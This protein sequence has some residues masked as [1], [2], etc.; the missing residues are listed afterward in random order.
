MNIETGSTFEGPIIITSRGTGY[1][2]IDKNL[3]IEVPVEAVNKA[4]DGDTVKVQVT[5]KDGGRNGEP[6]GEIVQIINRGKQYFVGTSRLENG[7]LFIVPDNHRMYINFKVPTYEGK[8][9]DN[10]KIYIK[11]QDWKDGNEFPEATVEKIIGKKGVHEVEMQSIILEQGFESGFSEKVEAEAKDFVSKWDEI[12]KEEIV[13]RKDMR[14]T[15]TFTIDP[16]NAKDFDDAL[17][18]KKLENGNYEIGIHIADVSYFVRPGS[19]LDKEAFDRSF[20]VYLV[21]RTIPMLPEALSN[22]L[23]SLKPEVERLA[24]S[25]IFEITPEAE[26]VS[27]WYGRTIIKSDKRFTYEEA[28]QI[29]DNNSGEF[30]DELN[31][32][33][34]ISKKLG[35]EKMQ[36]GAIRFERDEFEFELDKDGVPIKIHKKEH[37]DTHSLIEEFMLLSNKSVAK[38]I[39]DEDKKKNDGKI[40]QLM[41]RV[42]NPPEIDKIKELH[43]FLKI[44]G[45]ELRVD[46]DGLVSPSAINALLDEVKGKPEEDLISSATIKTMSKAIYS[47]ENLGHFG[48][49]FKYYTHFTSPIRRYPDLIVHRILD[50]LLKNQKIS[51]DEMAYF[52][53]SA[54]QSSNQEVA[55]QDAERQ[56]IRYKQ[57]EFM[58]N[59]IGEEFDG[60]ISGVAKFG[61]FVTLND[62][63]ANGMV[64]ISNLGEDFYKF[65]EKNYRIVGERNGEKYTL[66][67]QVRVKIAEANLDEKQLQ[68]KIVENK[69]TKK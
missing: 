15:T 65:D 55:A 42:H 37:I 22:D 45:Y 64:H 24:F 49:A 18:I 67:D 33:N 46:K 50:H 56:S 36:N 14:G 68:M 53:K 19:E 60:I 5:S 4:F 8:I 34:T 69:T 16:Y 35:K 30:Y 66:G 61:L 62:T 7:E 44:L 28:Q 27:E 13:D 9:E 48:L 1:F 39:F 63:G 6:Q 52:K 3:S 17:S 41:Y 21:D 38:Y 10:T 2:N 54:E 11:F 59:H 43:D 12:L 47:T 31:T 57:V 58:M 26:V 40:G 29:L 32:L 23:C 51:G 25:T 20:S